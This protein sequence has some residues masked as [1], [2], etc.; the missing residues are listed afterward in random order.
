MGPT[1]PA[2]S[3]GEGAVSQRS[4]ARPGAATDTYT[5][6]EQSMAD[7]VISEP[8][9]HNQAGSDAPEGAWL[10]QRKRSGEAP[11]APGKEAPGLGDGAGVTSAKGLCSA[12]R[13]IDSVSTASTKARAGASC[14]WA[15]KASTRLCSI[16]PRSGSSSLRATF[17]W[18]KTS[19]KMQTAKLSDLSKTSKTPR[20]RIQPASNSTAKMKK[21]TATPTPSP[22]A[23]STGRCPSSA[24]P[25]EARDLRSI[26]PAVHQTTRK[27]AMFIPAR[28]TASLQRC[29]PVTWFRKKGCPGR[30]A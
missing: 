20:K 26:Q 11:A 27:D 7:R 15:L 29:F 17:R 14:K 6:I 1:P 12:E 23:Q 16:Q 10:V 9:S 3:V 4:R 2:A 18:K 28:T 13:S 30:E 8:S 25:R 24:S 19:Q 21:T 5:V 22:R